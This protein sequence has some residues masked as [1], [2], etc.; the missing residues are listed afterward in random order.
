VPVVALP[1]GAE[2]EANA[3]AF[4]R[5]RLTATLLRME[6]GYR[7]CCGLSRATGTRGL[8]ADR[9]GTPR[10]ASVSSTMITPKQ[11]CLW[12]RFRPNHQY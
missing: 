5:T 6:V 3:D 1:A 11:S 7:R 2:T 4:G 10:C 9:S 8:A 12:R